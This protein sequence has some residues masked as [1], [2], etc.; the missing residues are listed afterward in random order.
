VFII[1]SLLPFVCCYHSISFG[2]VISWTLVYE[3]PNYWSWEKLISESST[4]K[5]VGTVFGKTHVEGEKGLELYLNGFDG[6]SEYVNQILNSDQIQDA[7]LRDKIQNLIS[8][9]GS[10][11]LFDFLRKNTV[12]V[13]TRK[14]FGFHFYWFICSNC[15]Y[16]P[17]AAFGTRPKR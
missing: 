15:S 4:F 14:E 9:T 13:K 16:L 5:K 12:V 11:S 7:I 6:D 2:V 1:L 17:I 3:N 10:K 8:K